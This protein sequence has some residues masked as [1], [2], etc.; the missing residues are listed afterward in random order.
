M[1]VGKKVSEAK[2]KACAFMVTVFLF[3]HV[4]LFVRSVKMIMMILSLGIQ[5]D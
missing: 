4:L 2:Q 1:L 3:F 5:N